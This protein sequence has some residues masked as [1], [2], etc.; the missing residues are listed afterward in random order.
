MS[1]GDSLFDPGNRLIAAL[2]VATEAQADA[3][4]AAL[5]TVPSFVKLGLELFCGFGPAL[6]QRLIAARLR[7][8]LDLKLH[9]IPE[10]VARTTAQLAALGVELCTVHA[11]SAAML[12]GAVQAARRGAAP[13]RPPMRILAVTVLTSMSEQDL[14]ESGTGGSSIAEVVRARAMLAVATGCDGIVASA[15][16]VAML[17]GLVPADFLLVTPGIRPVGVDAGD[18]QRVMTPGAAMAA[19][20]D[21]IVVGRPLRD[22]ADPAAAA[23]AIVA[24]MRTIRPD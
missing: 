24:E 10:T 15:H 18:Q 22:A 17:R 13:G 11:S 21:L 19:G 8:M 3:L 12:R 16:E 5:G 9:D 14:V 1:E 4:I 6:V 23:R 2:D 20:A 7:V